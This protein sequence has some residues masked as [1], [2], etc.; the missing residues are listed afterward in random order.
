MTDKRLTSRDVALLA[1]VSRTTV[2]YVLNG[3]DQS[4]GAET[5]LRV[6]E[7]ARQLGY[8]PDESARTLRKGFSDEICLFGVWPFRDQFNLEFAAALQEAIN[9]IGYSLLIY[10]N[11]NTTAQ[12]T[13]QRLAQVLAR[14]PVGIIS[15]TY[16][17]NAA[18]Y[19][20]ALKMGVKAFVLLDF[21]PATYAPTI[22]LPITRASFLVGKHLFDRGHRRIGLV[23][24]QSTWHTAE[25][26]CRIDGLTQ[27][28]RDYFGDND[29]QLTQ[30][31]LRGNLANTR[32][33]IGALLHSNDRPSA[34]YGY[35]D[36]Y[37]FQ[38]M[39]VLLESG[40]RIPDEMAVVGTDNT[41]LCELFHPSLTSVQFD[42]LGLTN[43]CVQAL[44]IQIRGESLPQDI[45]EGMEPVL[46]PRQ[47]S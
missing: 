7:A 6:L 17:I 21:K 41:S 28:A 33:V 15:S 30:I 43:R 10:T 25:V 32:Q 12:K 47:S 20:Q 38:V 36:A 27:A 22:S 19:K 44:Q 2:S 13:T 14:R 3:K 34:I 1:G 45:L 23:V 26:N 35:N 31:P 40:V 11:I 46:F 29:F 18:N 9:H 4:I 8:Q 24:P 16:E 5:R 37:S 42:L 39:K